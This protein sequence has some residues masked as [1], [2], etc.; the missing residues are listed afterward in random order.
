MVLAK[1]TKKGE[2]LMKTKSITKRLKLHKTTLSNLEPKKMKEI[3]G[4][5]TTPIP[6]TNLNMSCAK[7]CI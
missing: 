2:T 4:G 7:S 5:E 1:I 3:I 6:K